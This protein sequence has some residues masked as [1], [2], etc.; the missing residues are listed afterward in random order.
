MGR[1]LLR[2]TVLVLA[3]IEMGWNAGVA[4]AAGTASKEAE[5]PEGLLDPRFDL[6]IW[7][8]V[9]FVILFLVLRRWAWG[10]MLQGLKTREETI[11]HALEEARKAQDDAHRLR[12]QF[13]AEMNKAHEKVRD[14][15]DEARREAGKLKADE[16]ARTRAEIATERDRLRREIETARDQALQELWN[17]TAQLA[18]LVSAK[19][20]RRQLTPEDHRR[21]MDEAIAELQ[22]AGTQRKQQVASIRA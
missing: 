2:V 1:G 7:T 6:G 13:Q 8:I 5:K 9:V 18:T 15:L 3:L 16:M 14:V 22:Q 20:I 4:W 19:A 17:Q 11:H 12:E 21:L 10:P